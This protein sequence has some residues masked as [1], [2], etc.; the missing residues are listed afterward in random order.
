MPP[1]LIVL[2]TKLDKILSSIEGK[3]G[4]PNDKLSNIIPSADGSTLP[5][6]ETKKIPDTS[7]KRLGTFFET[8]KF[9]K[10]NTVLK[11]ARNFADGFLPKLSVTLTDVFK[12]ITKALTSIAKSKSTGE[13]SGGASPLGDFGGVAKNLLIFIPALGA[14]TYIAMQWGGIEVSSIVKMFTA[15]SIFFGGIIALDK[16]KSKINIS[17]VSVA[18]TLLMLAGLAGVVMLF[19]KS[20]E[21]WES[22]EL[23]SIGKVVLVIGGIAGI[24]AALAFI[25]KP[26]LLAGIAA[27]AGIE[28]L[29]LGLSLILPLLSTG[30]SSLSGVNWSELGKAAAIITG[31]GVIAGALGALAATGI[32]AV[33]LAAGAAAFAGILA[34]AY[35]L[36]MVLPPLA[37]AV[38]SLSGVKWEDLGKAGV[39]IAGISTLATAMGVATPFVIAANLGMSAFSE[40][41]DGITNVIN[42]VVT[43]VTSLS[44]ISSDGITGGFAKIKQFIE[45]TSTL[46]TGEGFIGKVGGFIKNLATGGAAS[47][48]V[49]PYIA[50][51]FEIQTLSSII[52]N[53]VTNINK[54]GSADSINSTMTF[55]KSFLDGTGMFG[56]LVVTDNISN[57]TNSLISL[58][59]IVPNINA[60]S[61]SLEYLGSTMLSFAKVNPFSTFETAKTTIDSLTESV[62]RLKTSFGDIDVKSS[63]NVVS[64]TPLKVDMTTTNEIL[65]K[66]YQTSV[67]MV[68]VLKN[69]P[70]GGNNIIMGSGQRSQGIQLGSPKISGFDGFK[71]SPYAY[72]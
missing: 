41:V 32:G 9:V 5:G 50:L 47:A 21:G 4:V 17:L 72:R 3:K 46:F 14:F 37:T 42:K 27:F 12:P 31:I 52:A 71:G 7:L 65:Y 61:I 63:I 19:K 48:L 34:L 40:F 6:Q 22:I 54:V 26:L 10:R 66:M 59:S 11:Y 36:S 55:I 44:K 38:Q 60:L 69:L 45:S 67:E 1:E 58:T 35:G 57:I 8:G 28:A 23:A 62:N 56:G 53:T 18:S 30:I 13:T 43:T 29:A 68:S 15:L 51:A 24:V 2:V 16:L 20:L 49:A 25:P 39:V 70:A 33:A 64:E